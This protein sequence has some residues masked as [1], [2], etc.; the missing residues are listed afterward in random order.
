MS[1]E[2]SFSHLLNG[3]DSIIED[4]RQRNNS[5]S[6]S[7]NIFNVIHM[8]SNE[9]SVHSAFISDLLNPNGR[10]TYGDRFLAAF[11]GIICKEF[12]FSTEGARVEIERFIGQKTKTTGG[13]IDIIVTNKDGKAIIIENKIYAGDQ[14][15]Q[16]VRYTH[17]AQK[18]FKDYILL[19]LTLDG[20]EA[21]DLSAA[22]EEGQ[23]EYKR[24]S[25]ADD[26]RAW[27]EECLRLAEGR[28]LLASGLTHYINLIKKLTH[29]DMNAENK[30][31]LMEHVLSEPSHIENLNN[32]ISILSSAKG[33]LLETFWERLAERLSS[34]NKHVSLFS[35]NKKEYSEHKVEELTQ[36][37]S[38]FKFNGDRKNYDYQFGIQIPV[39]E[40][41]N[42]QQL[43][44]GIIVDGTLSMRAFVVDQ[45]E[46]LVTARDTEESFHRLIELSDEKA[47]KWINDEGVYVCV[48]YFTSH[49]DEWNF[50]QM[51]D[52]TL[53]QLADMDSM[54]EE[55]VR[56]FNSYTDTITR[57]IEPKG[58][59]H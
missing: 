38:M 42:G 56:S 26:I 33:K 37:A 58:E 59:G 55:T 13:R 31:E 5:V 50:F 15:D 17:Y 4:Q 54:I 23:V 9:T 1:E 43:K 46:N 16:L 51:P 2:S 41:L 52:Q 36:L 28:Y 47:K 8:E 24:I 20:H 22:T 32:Y 14:E 45:N 35:R 49:N 34:G 27:L 6:G 30:N 44:T 25:Y 39:G 48:R 10:H 11:T 12:E 19:Y 57:A 7:Y 18:N 29:T 53:R 21:S 40:P 3:I